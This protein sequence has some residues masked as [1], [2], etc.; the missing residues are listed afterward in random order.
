MNELIKKSINSNKNALN[1]LESKIETIKSI[2]SLAITSLKNKGKIIFMGNG[3]SAADS[4]HLAAELIG[5]FKK[6]RPALA[7]IA[8]ST[9]TSILTAIGNDFG[10]DDIFLRQI[11]ALTNLNDIVIAISTSGNSKNV[12]KAIEKAKKLGAKTVGFLGMDGGLLKDIVD[13]PFIIEIN[14][15]PR[16]QEMH[17]LAGHIICEIIENHFFPN[18]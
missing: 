17:I 5:R 7:S 10:F 1:C 3:G 13:I 8:L 18:N 6:N 12:I 16:V 14:D 2:A 9:N 11:E 4:Q 15:T